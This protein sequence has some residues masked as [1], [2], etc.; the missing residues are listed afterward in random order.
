MISSVFDHLKGWIRETLGDIEVS[1]HPPSPDCGERAVR[2]YLKDVTASPSSGTVLKMDRLQIQLTYLVTTNGKTL[3]E[4][5][6]DLAKLI[7]SAMLAQGMTVDLSPLSPLEW[8]AFGIVPR[9]SF[10]LKTPLTFTVEK[11]AV[12]RVEKPLVISSSTFS[13]QKADKRPK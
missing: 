13:G 10:L 4:A 6:D 11:P 12:K 5:D 9:P 7:F 1:P 8:Q 2:L 3:P